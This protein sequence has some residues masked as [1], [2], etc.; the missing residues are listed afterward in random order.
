MKIKIFLVDDHKMFREAIRIHLASQEHI[1]VVGEAG[2]GQDAL[3]QIGKLLPDMV[4][5]DIRLPDM[6]GIDVAR[7]IREISPASRILALTAYADPQSVNQIL[8]LGAG[9]YI[10]K[11]AGKDVLLTA[12]QAV[13][14]GHIYLS[15]EITANALQNPPSDSTPEAIK[16]LG[17]RE[18]EVLKLL[19][20]GMSSS[21]IARQLGISGSTVSVHR[22]NIKN[23]LKTHTMA[24]LIRL[25]IR[26]GL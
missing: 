20:A 1:E 4:L 15:P 21:D 16:R 13:S 22:K 19:A 11:T 9:A 24:E 12:I 6:S 26:E 3:D 14:A 17:R 5:L 7:I 10:V 18:M 23:K 25:A 8:R 2:N